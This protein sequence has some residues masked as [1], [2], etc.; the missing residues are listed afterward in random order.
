LGG[1]AA[2]AKRPILKSVPTF[3]CRSLSGL[4]SQSRK[5]AMRRL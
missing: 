4:R 3:S 1:A 2:L 5:P